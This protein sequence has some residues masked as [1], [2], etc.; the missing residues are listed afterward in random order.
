MKYDLIPLTKIEI[1][2][3]KI[4]GRGVFA[5]QDLKKGELIEEAHFI[6]SGK[7]KRLQDKE[8]G[9]YVF[10]MF[11]NEKLTPQENERLNFQIILKSMIPDEDLR[12]DLE[13][14][15]KDLGY[16]DLTSIFSVA[17]VLGYGMIYNHSNEANVDFDLDY[18][19]FVFKYT[20]NQS[21]KKGEE[22]FINYG[23][24]KRKD[25]K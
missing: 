2:K 18:N 8:L 14:E 1:G 24:D 11:Y 6:I 9:R 4:R 19:D 13:E 16:S 25:L 22:L 15:I 10:S 21:I 17:V 20:T 5:S 23:N 12:K 3:S 7:T